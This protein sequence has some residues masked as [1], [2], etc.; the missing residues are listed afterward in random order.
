MGP[1]D[2]VASATTVRR[3]DARRPHPLP[4]PSRRPSGQLLPLVRLATPRRR[5]WSCSARPLGAFWGW[6]RPV[7][8]ANFAITDGLPKAL[9]IGELTKQLKDKY[10]VLDRVEVRVVDGIRP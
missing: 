4:A 2:P 3:R 8:G 7:A 5:A 10:V 9:F 6:T 1:G